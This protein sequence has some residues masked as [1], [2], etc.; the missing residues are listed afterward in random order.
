MYS[1]VMAT[2]LLSGGEATSWGHGCHGCCGCWGC[3]GYPGYACSC[4][5][6]G[7]YGCHG[8]CGCWGCYGCS[9][10]GCSCYGCYCSC[11]CWGYSYYSSCMSCYGCYCSGCCGG[12][13]CS[14]SGVVIALPSCS[15]SCSCSC[16][17]MAAV[18]GGAAPYSIMPGGGAEL[19]PQP[20]ATMPPATDG[21]TPRTQAERDAVRKLLERMRD[22]KSKDEETS[23]PAAPQSGG[24]ALPARL[25]VKLPTDARLWVDQVECPLTSDERSFNTPVLQP[26]QTYYYTLKMQVQRE[27]ETKTETRRVLVNA[28]QNVNVTFR[29]PQVLTTAER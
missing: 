2:L 7:C 18:S 28:G 23:A 25:T 22:S 5:C 10:Y 20:K 29:E 14:C 1:V 9:C 8:C 19:V 17:G 11:S 26:G 4:S 24:Q 12:N 21:T 3:H 13:F 6:Y 16:A 27:G 15:C